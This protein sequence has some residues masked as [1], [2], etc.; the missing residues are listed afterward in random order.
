MLNS[1]RTKLLVISILILTVPLILVGIF[2][3]HKSAKSLDDLG[4]LNLTNSVE[5]T[6][7]M[8][9]ALN[10]E[11][12]N[13]NLSLADAQERVKQAILGE[14]NADGTRPINKNIDLGENGYLFVIGSDGLQLAHPSLEGENIWEVEDP[15]GMKMAQEVINAGQ[16]GGG[17]TYF[18]WPLPGTEDVIEPKVS[19]SKEDP[20][21]GW[22]VVSSTYMQDFNKP[23][24]S[25][26]SLI[27]ILTVIALL[28]GG[29]V[30]WLFANY[31]S[32]PIQ[33]VTEH[34][35]GL[36][37]GDLA[38]EAIQ[39]RSKD[40]TGQLS[41]AMN[42]LQN[43]LNGIMTDLAIDSVKITNQSSALT[44][45][46]NEVT[47][48][49]EQV[50]ETMQELAKGS[51][52]QAGHATS[53]SEEMGSF[54]EKVQEANENGE[55]IQ[56]ASK[57]VIEMTDE[58]VA[59]MET[60]TEQMAE[61]DR[62]VHEAVEKVEGLDTHA[63]EISQLVSVIR[64]IADQTN[65][66]A[67]N[68]AIEAARAGENGQGFAVVADEVRKLA[69]ESSNSVTNITDIVA[70]IQNESSLVSESLQDSYKEVEQGTEQIMTTGEMFKDI[71][72]A[73]SDMAERINQISSN[74]QEISM[75]T[76]EMN[77]HIQEVAAISEEAAAGVEQT[78]AA[79]EQT[80]ASMEEVAASSEDLAKLA[81]GLNALVCQF[82]LSRK[83]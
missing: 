70:R 59:L 58:G 82:E 63:Q 10:E 40:E 16:S 77:S 65:L 56:K 51:E 73:V 42:D 52:A 9:E 57:K 46:A 22:I 28:I 17:L 55:Y 61:I 37:R 81:E 31:L 47:L 78:S 26:K 32:K 62:I 18:D 53:L 25:L 6:I 12:E 74:L 39:V 45:S 27:M 7:E 80:N 14:Q 21:W 20:Y 48:A 4:V 72:A 83:S 69:V 29:V 67:L 54:T 5:M 66:L 75:N 36:A 23:A 43:Q 34:M 49:T 50:A 1:L 33:I 76:I 11:V 44:Q 64:D 41:L 15:K 3:Y 30:V 68:A 13:G 38:Q 71:T 60:S 35:K 24:E 19:Y 2:S 79:T 8:I